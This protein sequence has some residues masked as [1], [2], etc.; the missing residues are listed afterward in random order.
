M[1]NSQGI[2]QRHGQGLFYH[3]AETVL[4]RGLDHLTVL[5]NRGVDQ[6]RLRMPSCNHRVHLRIEKAGVKMKLLCVAVAE[7]GIR[8]HN[9]HQLHFL[10]LGKLLQETPDMPVFQADDRNPERF[11]AERAATAQAHDG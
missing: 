1:A 3:H 4:R 9:A 10:L 7:L 11:L 2:L 6:Q 8:V 5:P